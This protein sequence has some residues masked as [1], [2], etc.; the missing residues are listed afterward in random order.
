[1]IADTG[2]ASFDEP[3]LECGTRIN[4]ALVLLCSDSADSQGKEIRI[5]RIGGAAGERQMVSSGTAFQVVPKIVHLHFILRES[6]IVLFN[7]NLSK[8]EWP[9]ADRNI[10][11]RRKWLDP[12]YG[13]VAVDT[14]EKEEELERLGH[15]LSRLF[16]V[17]G[18]GVSGRPFLRNGVH[19]FLL[20][21]QGE[22][23][24]LRPTL[25]QRAFRECALK[26]AI[27]AFIIVTGRDRLA[28]LAAVPTASSLSSATGKG[29]G[30]ETRTLGFGASMIRP[31]STS[32]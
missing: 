13:K 9:P 2:L 27:Q 26:G 16:A 6:G 19:P 3:F 32:P 11:R 29:A 15:C 7:Q 25:E 8:I 12:H 28:I 30:D 21:V 1:M 22:G 31:V 23:G 17:L 14:A 18:I 4:C 24:V 5:G 10:G 20:I